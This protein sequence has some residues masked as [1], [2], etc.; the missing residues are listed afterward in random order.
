MPYGAGDER[1]PEF[2]EPSPVV[3][4]ESSAPVYSAETRWFNGRPVRPARTITMLVTAYSPDWRSCGDSADGITATQHHVET[5]AHDMVAADP[6]ILPYGSLV[7]I[8]GY[9]HDDRGNPMIVPVLDCGGKIKGRRLDVLYPTHN[10]AVR[11]GAQRLTVTV[12]EYA[13]GKPSG[14][15]KQRR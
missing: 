3:V 7:T 9:A 4:V 6:R 11:W 12:W 14:F 1:L 15:R 2:D 5:N 13:D 10:E 8:P